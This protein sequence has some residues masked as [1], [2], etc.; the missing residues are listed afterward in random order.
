MAQNS[1]AAVDRL[2]S[3]FVDT[4]PRPATVTP[5][6]VL[7]HRAA[8]R[9]VNDLQTLCYA[10]P[11]AVHVLATWS[12]EFRRNLPP[13]LYVAHREDRTRM[14]KEDDTKESVRRLFDLIE[15]LAPK[16][17]IAVQA[18]EHVIRAFVVEEGRQLVAARLQQMGPEEVE[19]MVKLSAQLID[20]PART[21][22]SD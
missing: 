12:H 5:H 10:D 18:V 15:V 17:P 8:L 20:Q 2:R 19:Q 3:P 11:P 1:G 21:G 6:A 16:R 9:I 22:P 7:T 14:A 13:T 4:K